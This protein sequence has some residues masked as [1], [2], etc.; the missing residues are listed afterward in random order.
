MDLKFRGVRSTPKGDFIISTEMKTNMGRS[1]PEYL[2]RVGGWFNYPDG[3]LVENL[4]VW[5][6]LGEMRKKHV[7]GKKLHKINPPYV[8]DWNRDISV[9]VYTPEITEGKPIVFVSCSSSSP[10]ELTPIDTA[11]FG[12]NLNRHTIYEGSEKAVDMQRIWNNTTGLSEVYNKF[13]TEKYR[14]HIVVFVHDDVYL[15]DGLVVEKLHEAHSEF[16]VVGLAGGGQVINFDAP[17]WHI[18]T[19]KSTQSGFVSHVF[20]DGKTNMAVF[21]DSK[22]EVTLLDGLFLSV[23]VSA[24]L[25]ADVTFDEDF[26]F[27][28]YDLAFCLRASRAGLKLGT[29]PIFV[30]HEGL[31][32][33]DG[34]WHDLRPKFI[35]RYK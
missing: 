18:M 12:R 27:H 9:P 13:I 6:K 19:D 34:R 4:D 30:R 24:V 16:D 20:P 5:H 29:W 1:E 23:D 21:G 22:K 32:E 7:D 28:F 14:D 33:P 31:G 15:D 35:E 8:E 2:N 10:E 3:T 11:L 25:D 17:L 26:D